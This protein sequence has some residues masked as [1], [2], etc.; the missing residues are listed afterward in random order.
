MFYGNTISSI[1]RSNSIVSL[2]KS[3]EEISRENRPI[4]HPPATGSELA[5]TRSV[6]EVLKEISRKRISSDVSK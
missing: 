1:I 6:L 2:H 4:L 3:D 5:P